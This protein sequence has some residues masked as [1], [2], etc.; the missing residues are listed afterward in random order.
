ML[1]HQTGQD[2][3]IIAAADLSRASEGI[4]V[5]EFHNPEAAV[6]LEHVHHKFP[7]THGNTYFSFGDKNYHWKAHSA[8]VEDDTRI[9]LGVHHKANLGGTLHKFGSMILTHEGLKLKDVVVVT[10]L[11]EQ[12]R[13]DEARLEVRL[14]QFHRANFYRNSK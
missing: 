1:I 3:P 14:P 6:R 5:I 9:C 11:V 12:A 4:C 13:S 7:F 10:G 2:S 8:L